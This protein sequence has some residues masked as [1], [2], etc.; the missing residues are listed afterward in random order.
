MARK[1]K[2]IKV[3]KYKGNTYFTVPIPVRRSEQQ[4]DLFKDF[5]QCRL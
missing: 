1:E 2:Y 5:Q 3:K 4:A